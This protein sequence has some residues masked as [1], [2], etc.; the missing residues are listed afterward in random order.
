MVDMAT[1]AANPCAGAHVGGAW[2]YAVTPSV[3][4]DATG[5]AIYSGTSTVTLSEGTTGTVTGARGSR[6][7]SWSNG[8]TYTE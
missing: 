3:T 4:L 5:C 7:I 6:T 8:I 2:T 1:D